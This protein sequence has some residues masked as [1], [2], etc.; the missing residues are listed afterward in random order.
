MITL[1]LYLPELHLRRA[2]AALVDS[3]ATDLNHRSTYYSE[4]ISNSCSSNNNINFHLESRRSF[5]KARRQEYGDE[6]Y[7]NAS[8]AFEAANIGRTVKAGAVSLMES[9]IESL[10]RE[11]TKL[12]TGRASPGMLDHIMVESDGAKKPLNRLALVS[13]LD[14]K[15]LA[16]SPYD[17][18]TLKELEKAIVASP[19]GI[20]PKPDNQR[21][22]APIPPLTKEHT[23]A[24]CKVV[25]KSSEDVKQVLTS[26]GIG[27][28]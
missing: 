18:N 28:N 10:T 9:A 25:A 3:S 19:L 2:A 27:Y 24:I 15:T 20:N 26:K 4:L 13:V 14:P 6:D 11:L 8:N 7:D 17:P 22:L 12:R 21:L 5:A 23:Q 1:E 16:I